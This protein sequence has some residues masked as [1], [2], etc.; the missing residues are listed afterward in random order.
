MAVER[1]NK[2]KQEKGDRFKWNDEGKRTKFKS[3]MEMIVLD[4]LKYGS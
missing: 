2:I 1:A 3:R 4:G